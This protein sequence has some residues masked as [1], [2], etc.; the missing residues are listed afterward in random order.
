MSYL[1][2][3]FLFINK[4]MFLVQKVACLSTLKP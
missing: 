2:H 3:M 1:C 4:F